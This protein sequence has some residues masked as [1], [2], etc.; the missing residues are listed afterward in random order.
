M[1][2]KGKD[3]KL[4]GTDSEQ[5]VSAAPALCPALQGSL[6]SGQA[7]LA[8]GLVPTSPVTF[9]FWFVCL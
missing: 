5:E 2:S 1:G 9:S 8:G 6:A 3:K 4:S 7:K